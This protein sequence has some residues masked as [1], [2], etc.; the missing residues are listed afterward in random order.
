MINGNRKIAIPDILV[1]DL[2]N[3]PQIIQYNKPKNLKNEPDV[4]LIAHIPQYKIKLNWIISF[5]QIG[6]GTKFTIQISLII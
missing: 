5:G 3:I 6:K 1:Y 2:R 4:H